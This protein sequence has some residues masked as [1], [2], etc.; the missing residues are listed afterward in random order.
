MA[1]KAT[2]TGTWLGGDRVDLDTFLGAVDGSDASAH[3]HLA[4][5]AGQPGCC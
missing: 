2:V 4:H 3:A 1:D 5:R